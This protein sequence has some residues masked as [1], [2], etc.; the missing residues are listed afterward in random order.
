[1]RRESSPRGVDGDERLLRAGE[2]ADQVGGSAVDLDDVSPRRVHAP[3]KPPTVGKAEVGQALRWSESRSR[4]TTVN[5]LVNGVGSRVRHVCGIAADCAGTVALGSYVRSSVIH[6]S[7]IR[8][9]VLPTN[10]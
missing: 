1:L 6:V 4:W 3:M 5:R 8:G 2:E 7:T 10:R 9:R